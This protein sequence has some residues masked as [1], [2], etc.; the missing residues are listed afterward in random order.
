[1]QFGI[2]FL[3][4]SDA[5][6]VL[7][8]ARD[9]ERHEHLDRLWVADEKFLRDPWVQLGG[10]A[11]VTSRVSIGI[12][13][14]E[15]YIRH[16]ALTATAA[17]TLQELSGGRAILGLGAGST[18]FEA[19]GIAQR[20]PARAITECIEL[21]RKMW[22]EPAPFSYK[23]EQVRFADSRLD[24]KPPSPIPIYVAARGPKMLATAAR[25]AD[26]VLIGSFAQGRGL[27][28][29]LK[30]IREAEAGR[31]P[32]LPPLRKAAWIYVSVSPHAED[33]QRGAERGLA[34][35][36]RSSHAMLTA[37]GYVIPAE[38]LDFILKGTHSL[39]DDEVDWVVA[40]LPHELVEDLTVA[41]DVTQCVTKLR[42]MSDRGVEE[43]AI[44]PFA[45]SG[46][47]MKDMVDLL[48]TEVAP[49]LSSRS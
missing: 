34:L 14:T 30:T 21:C 49:Q 22:T 13:V 32:E 17:A 25:L 31:K 40:R 36:V 19:L 18:G 20:A 41:G 23:G 37:I 29:A 6:E 15:P 24:F 1:M 42:G 8:W 3:G 2:G 44:L 7:G 33:A 43:V 46:G 9:L 45:P 11:A 39:T 26:A 48:L 35:A 47:N 4:D 27:D 16:P 5:R 12:C 38:V 10:I 28:Y